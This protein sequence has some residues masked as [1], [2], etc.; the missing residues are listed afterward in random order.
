M[1]WKISAGV[2]MALAFL[3]PAAPAVAQTGSPGLD[4]TCQTGERKVYQDIRKLVTIDP[5]T[6]SVTDLRVQGAR[7]LD[8]ATDSL[9]TLLKGIQ[10]GLNGTTDDLRAFLKTGLLNAWTT[11]LRLAAN[12]T[13]TGAGANV[14]AA[15]QKALDDGTI[16]VLLA[17]LND[18]LYDARALDCAAQPPP[19]ASASTPASPS[20]SSSAAAAGTL[21][22]TGANTSVLALGAGALILFGIAGVLVARRF[23]T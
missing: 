15:A 19:S 3:I 23:R 9:P 4:Q 13:M 2:L 16:D 17:Y 18:G 21:P 6:A 5:D 8:A 7:I 12:Q 1:R 22:V 20:V 14:K 11:D 10:Q